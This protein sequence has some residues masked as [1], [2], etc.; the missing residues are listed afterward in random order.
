MELYLKAGS[1]GKSVGDCPFAHFVR[2]AI[3]FKG[4]ECEVSLENIIFIKKL[5]FKFG[6][7]LVCLGSI[8]F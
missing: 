4:L 5:N 7:G 8:F 3:S 6:W 1:D 2:A